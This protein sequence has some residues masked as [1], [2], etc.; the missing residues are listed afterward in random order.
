LV[1]VVTVPVYLNGQHQRSA[2]EIDDIIAQ[3]FLAGELEM[4]ETFMLQ[5]LEPELSFRRGWVFAVL[6][7]LLG[8]GLV[9]GNV[10]TPLA[11]LIREEILDRQNT[12]PKMLFPK[13]P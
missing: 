10:R 6:T 8:Q 7:C 11:P 3:R 9:V 2:I 1:L 5:H 13:P 12:P 4:I